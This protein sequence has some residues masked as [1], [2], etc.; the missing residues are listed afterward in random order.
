LRGQ[1]RTRASDPAKADRPRSLQSQTATRRVGQSDHEK[2]IGGRV[3]RKNY[4]LIEEDRGHN[5]LDRR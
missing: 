3:K 5:D 1:T 4:V 2:E